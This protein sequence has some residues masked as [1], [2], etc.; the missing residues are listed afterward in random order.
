MKGKLM[1]YVDQYGNQWYAKTVAELHSKIG[2]GKISKMY[3]DHG[4]HSYHIGYCV[5]QHWCS[6]F[7]PYQQM[8]H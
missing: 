1:L 2:H 8:E 3:I 4:S 5:G 7:V 6:A